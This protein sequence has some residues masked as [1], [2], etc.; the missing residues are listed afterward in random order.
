MRAPPPAPIVALEALAA[1][2]ERWLDLWRRLGFAPI[3]EAWTARAHGLGEA[4]EA[5]LSDE[6]VAGV[7]EGLDGDGALRLRTSAG[8]VRRITAGDVMFGSA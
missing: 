6:T 8:T 2:F 3:A 4:C 7:A 5:R 1:S